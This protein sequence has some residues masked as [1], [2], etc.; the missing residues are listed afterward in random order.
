[1][2]N[3]NALERILA[4]YAGAYV[5]VAAADIRKLVEQLEAEASAACNALAERHEELMNLRAELSRASATAQEL[6][7]Y[8][9]NVSCNVYDSQGRPLGKWVPLNRLQARFAG[10]RL[11]PAP[12][13]EPSP[14][15]AQFMFE[16]ACSGLRYASPG[17]CGEVAAIH[18]GGV[19]YAVSSPDAAQGGEQG[20][21]PQEIIDAIVA[22]D[23]FLNEPPQDECR[24]T[25]REYRHEA[26]PKWDTLATMLRKRFRMYPYKFAAVEN[27]APR[28]SQAGAVAV[29]DGKAD[30]K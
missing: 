9:E 5:E 21:V 30:A 27:R 19:R 23:A 28:P 18:V 25:V 14:D 26:Y 6:Q 10:M 2:N 12:S 11:I 22:F 20:E 24:R 17:A 29:E 3:G 1:M 16:A 13:A 8:F 7:D 4:K 15:A